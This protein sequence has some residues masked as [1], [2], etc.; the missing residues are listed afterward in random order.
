MEKP[1]ATKTLIAVI[2]EDA[3]IPAVREEMVTFRLPAPGPR[4]SRVSSERFSVRPLSDSARPPRQSALR[5]LLLPNATR[6]GKC[7]RAWRGGSPGGAPGPRAG[8]RVRRSARA[9]DFRPGRRGRHRAR[10]GTAG[11]A[12]LVSF[13]LAL[14]ACSPRR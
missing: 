2:K 6:A 14:T 3:S 1:L 11:A 4:W 13:F 10:P 9:S 7:D 12:R 8:A 5:T